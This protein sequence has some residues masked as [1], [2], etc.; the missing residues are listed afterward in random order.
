MKQQDLT[1]SVLVKANI[2]L[3]SRSPK[4]QTTK[5]TLTNNMIFYTKA[6]QNKY[7]N[8]KNIYK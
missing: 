3:C 1:Q 7:N 2:F 5:H 8:N 6:Q 4:T